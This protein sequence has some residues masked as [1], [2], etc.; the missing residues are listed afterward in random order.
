[1]RKDQGKIVV[2][3][4]EFIS[5]DVSLLILESACRQPAKTRK[6]ISGNAPVDFSD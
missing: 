2:S 3:L 4:L 5:P 1:M 6:T